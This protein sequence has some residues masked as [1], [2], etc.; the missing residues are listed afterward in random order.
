[1]VAAIG[2]Q[3]IGE[4]VHI[5]RSFFWKLITRLLEGPFVRA[6][7]DAMLK[8]SFFASH[9][10]EDK[11]P[12]SPNTPNGPCCTYNLGQ[13]HFTVKYNLDRSV[14]TVKL[15]K[16]LNL[17]LIE[18]DWSKPCNPY[19]IVQLLPD[20]RHQLQSTVQKKTTDPE[21]DETFEFEVCPTQWN[22]CQTFFSW[23]HEIIKVWFESSRG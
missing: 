15:V 1:M 13:A 22:V 6:R 18:R 12:S 5:T 8:M 7:K 4:W 14:L 23:I 2:Y 3:K 9:L 10:Q 19:V 20:Y 21:F 17:S 11:S 16:A